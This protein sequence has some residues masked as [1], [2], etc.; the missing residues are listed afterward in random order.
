MKYDNE[1]TNVLYKLS[2]LQKNLK[3]EREV[4]IFRDNGWG[5]DP[6]SKSCFSIIVD[7]NGQVDY[8]DISEEC[9]Q[10]LLKDGYLEHNTLQTCK[11]RGYHKYV[12]PTGIGHSGWQYV[13]NK[14]VKYD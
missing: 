3:E 1:P 8:G 4:A 12:G 6:K 9:F 7:G 10:L 5:D 11:D 14:E 13:P 2:H